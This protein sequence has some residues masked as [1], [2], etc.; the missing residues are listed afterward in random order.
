MKRI[1]TH[2][3]LL[4]QLVIIV[5]FIQA[6]IFQSN[7]NP[8]TFIVDTTGNEINW[9][10][11]PDFQLPF[12]VIYHG[13]PSSDSIAWPLCKGFSH[14]AEKGLDYTDTIWPEQRAYTWTGIA[15]ADNWALNTSQP[16][17]MIKS[18]WN[19]DIQGYREKWD[20]R[21]K[22][23]LDGRYKYNPPAGQARADII[24]ADL[25]WAWHSDDDILS[26]KDNSLVPVYYQGLADSEFISEYKK[27]MALLYAEPLK[28]ARDSLNE[29]ILLSSYAELPVR[30][31]WYGI[32]DTSWQAWTN[33]S[34]RIDYLMQ[35]T[36]GFMNSVFYNYH[37]FICPSVYYFYNVDSV[38]TADK[39]LAYNLFQ[40]EVNAAWSEK[41][42]LVYCWLN[43]HPCCS[44]KEAIKPYMAE[45]T[46]IFPLMSGAMGLYP[47]K[48][49]LPHGYDV[50]E[51]FIKGLYR[52]SMFNDFFDGNEIYVDPVSA[53]ECF[54]NEL[55][56]WRAV[57]NDD[58]I[59]IA[60]HNPFA[61]DQDTTFLQIVYDGWQETIGLVGKQVFLCSFR[62]WYTG[63]RKKTLHQLK[64]YPNQVIY[65]L[66][67]EQLVTSQ[68]E[69]L[70]FAGKN[71]WE[72]F[73]P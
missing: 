68:E 27:D 33:D 35:D 70:K 32:D 72:V 58:E 46:A 14:I 40:S 54:V 44:Q 36:S 57:V 26:I 22:V 24:I 61:E 19:N 15:N 16:W 13:L 65:I 7:C 8:D 64:I 52:L 47:W 49:A 55:P 31:T 6:Q 50:Y 21:L 30:R 45:A 53:H 43:Y 42:Q 28:L 67:P 29:N 59:L 71:Q 10:Q 4:F 18:P 39:Y 56:V 34:S 1:I 51:Y 3:L 17:R 2:I 38:M 23:V 12:T 60:V 9:Q 69:P 66:N 25:E 41:D 37:D 5:Q 73:I 20:H 48:P 11:F 62:M 63:E